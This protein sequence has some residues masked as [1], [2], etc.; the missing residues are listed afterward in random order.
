MVRFVRW[1]E[2]LLDGAH[3]EPDETLSRSENGG[4]IEAL[5]F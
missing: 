3:G 1:Q 4:T 5:E 2:F